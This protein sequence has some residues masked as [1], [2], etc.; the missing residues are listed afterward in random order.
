ME[1]GR[2]F[3]GVVAIA[4]ATLVL[5]SCAPPAPGGGVVPGQA[6]PESQTARKKILNMGLRT[7]IDASAPAQAVWVQ[8][9][10]ALA[11]RAMVK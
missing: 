8:V 10:E 9:S 5:A 1:A 3:S 6:Q 11:A 4:L 2:R 7:I